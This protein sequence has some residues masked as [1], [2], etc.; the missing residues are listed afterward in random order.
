M[1]LRDAW[2]SEAANWVAW[3]RTPGHDSYWTFHRDAFLELLP[4]P[5]GVTLDV[6]CGEGR[7]PR[8]LKIHGHEVIGIDASPTLIEHARQA[9]PDGDYRVADAAALPLADASMSLV[10][11]FMSLHDVDD[12]DAAVREI[13]RVMSPHAT[14]AVAVV[15]PINSSG[16][17]ESSRHDAEFRIGTYLDERNYVDVVERDGLCMRFAGRHRPLETYFATLGAVGL[18]VDRLVEVPDPTEPPGSRWRRVPLFLHLRARPTTDA[19]R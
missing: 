4:A 17:F 14:L 15:H 2:E 7:L 6:G 9:D 18:V 11:A 8:D 13:A 19:E 1:G 10:T 16:A 5:R 3:A 12:L